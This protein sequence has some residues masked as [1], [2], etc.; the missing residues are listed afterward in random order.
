M[1][2][3]LEEKIA[4][5]KDK[6]KKRGKKNQE[7]GDL[8]EIEEE[9]EDIETEMK[10]K[11][12]EFEERTKKG[13]LSDEDYARLLREHEDEME[14]LKAKLDRQKDR[15][16]Q[17]LLEKIAE[18]KRKKKMEQTEEEQR[19]KLLAALK[20]KETLS[21][22][23]LQMLQ[24]DIEQYDSDMTKA[25]SKKFDSGDVTQEEYESM[26]RKHQQNMVELQIKLRQE[27]SKLNAML[28]EQVAALE[29]RRIEPS[30]SE[31]S[32]DEFNVIPEA[33]A[34]QTQLWTTPV[35]SMALVM[36]PLLDEY[37]VRKKQELYTDPAIF[38]ELDAHAIRVAQTVSLVTE[39]TFSSMVDTLV[40][41]ANSQ[42]EKIRLIFRWITAQNC[43]EMDLHDAVDDTPL[44]VL[45]GIYEHKITWSTLFMR[46][47]RYAG[48]KCVE[49][50]GCAKMVGYSPGQSISP[51]DE[52]YRH[53]WNA[54]CIDEYWHFVDC[55]WGVSHIG[56]SSTF[57]PFRYQ[58]DEHYFL[59][60]PEVIIRT[61]FPND[62]PWQ[63]LR[64]P[65]TMEDFVN[66]IFLKPNFFT[67][68]FV[69]I[70]H[71]KCIIEAENGD[72]E[73]KLAF[74]KGY[75][76]NC[77]IFDEHL[78][79]AKTVNGIRF[80]AYVFQQQVA[81]NSLSFYIRL[82]DPGIY[83]LVF[84]SKK[85][86]LD[87]ELNPETSTEICRYKI[88]SHRPSSDRYPLP[89]STMNW[90]GP[91]GVENFGLFP[92]THFNAVVLCDG[93]AADVQFNFTGS[94]QVHCEVTAY[95][96]PVGQFKRYHLQGVGDGVVSFRFQPPCPGRF[97]FNLF[98]IFQ[99]GDTKQAIP[100]CS[101]LVVCREPKLN[102]TPYPYVSENTWGP[103]PA[104]D[105]FGL[106]NLNQSQPVI[107]TKDD[108]LNLQIGYSH[109]VRL[110]YTFMYH[111][112]QGTQDLTSTV[113]SQPEDGKTAFLL[114]MENPGHYHLMVFACDQNDQRADKIPVYNYLVIKE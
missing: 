35:Q 81:E 20:N 54:V 29:G 70:T 47:C 46:M 37:P 25:I 58:Y 67:Y 71:K 2:K 92:L 96:A 69:P 11:Q 36:M 48:L 76:V 61:H 60:D 17:T 15:Q 86:F 8:Q 104:F 85:H 75:V 39:P 106:R 91:I 72:L 99:A 3:S 18:R 7:D 114:F 28:A 4:E 45:K 32:D 102:V 78:A 83:Y 52:R 65:F 112:M 113:F 49:I 40:E 57:D 88:H 64:N 107:V 14:R 30:D 13:D 31:D 97:A 82:P 101:Y 108:D 94:V 44:G 77:E 24:E 43:Q 100:F 105:A 89:P 84:Y 98:I 5:R 16:R 90:W 1:K 66:D 50:A 12:K 103:C 111:Y 34:T 42:L 87:G 68:G 33:Q 53:T 80:T 6:V 27:K 26:M 62:P 63:L 73:I 74:T 10:G 38:R 41:P 55:N 110:G 56:S 51:N 22:E 23:Q 9:M 95:G 109:E 59:A 93:D 21:E 79:V 19:A